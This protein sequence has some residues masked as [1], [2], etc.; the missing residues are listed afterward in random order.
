M[1]QGFI[2]MQIGNA[3]LDHMCKEVIVPALQEEC[4]LSAKRVDKHN[5]GRLLKSEIIEFIQE[6]EIIIADLTNERPNCYL[7]VG[8]TM[9]IDK[10]QNLIMTAREDHNPDSPNYNKNGPKIHFDLSGYDILF[11]D[12]TKLDDFK[13]ELVKRIKR[14]QANSATVVDSKAVVKDRSWVIETKKRAYQILSNIQGVR[15]PGYMEIKF[16]PV[17]FKINANQ[18]I[19]IDAVKKSNIDT[20]GWPIGVVLENT[21]LAPKPTAEGIVAEVRNKVAKEYDY[22]TIRLNGDFFL[23]KSL[24]EDKEENSQIFLDTRIIR[25]TETLLFCARLYAVLGVPKT[26]PLNIIIRHGGL[27]RRT[28]SAA[29][30][31]RVLS[32]EYSTLENEAFKEQQVLLKD[33]EPNLVALVKDFTQPLFMLYDFFEPPQEV[34]EDLV[35]N[36]V[37]G[38]V[39]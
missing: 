1:K 21:E 27:A 19:L 20:F 7:E 6:S 12:P 9:G 38:R 10:F 17:D 28:L 14:R 31:S 35:N 37:E 23:L 36:F 2:I 5:Q 25:V 13:M 15:T 32:S 30:T 11:W 8:Y 29:K 24:F 26:A 39:V 3:E 33:I 34:Y 22:W 18:R 4:G 16:S